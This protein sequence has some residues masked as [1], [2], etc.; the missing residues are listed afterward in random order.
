MTVTF[1]THA[2]A[3]GF[4]GWTAKHG[5]PIGEGFTREEAINALLRKLPPEIRSSIEQK[6]FEIEK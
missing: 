4:P 2:Q 5:W 6:T 3:A 1:N